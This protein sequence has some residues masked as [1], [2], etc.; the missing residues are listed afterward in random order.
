MTVPHLSAVDFTGFG[1]GH[2]TEL[3][4]RLGAVVLD[5]EVDGRRVR[6]TR[7]SV[8]APNAQAVRLVG[9]F[10]GWQG[11]RTWLERIEGTGI[12]ATFCEG[13]GS[14]ALYKFEVQTADGSWLTK[15][16][17]MARFCESA[18]HTA[19]IVYES[20]YRWNDDDWLWYRGETQ[21]HAAPMSVYEVHLGSWRPGLGYSQ[22]ADELVAHVTAM[23]FTHVEFLPVAEHPYRGSWGY[24]VTGFF[25]PQSRLGT[26][27][28][29]R[30]LV[31][32]LHRAG[33]GVIMDWVPGHFATDEWA[34][35][36]FDGTALYEHPDPRRGWHPDWGS[37]I[38]DFGR[39]EVRSFLLSNALWWVDQFHIDALRVDAVAS[40][41][42]LDYS[43]PDGGWE[44]NVHGGREN[45][46]A[47]SLLQEVNSHLYAR[48]PGVTMIAEESTT[49]PGVTRRVDQGGLGFG[50]K[51]NMGWM[52]DSLGYLGR[53]PEHR[54][55]HHHELTF[56]MTYS[57]SEN[58]VLPIS[59]DEVVHGKGSMYERVPEDP[60]RKFA[61]LKAYYAFMWSHPGKQLIFMGTEFAQRRE[62][63]EERGIDWQESDQWGHRA[64]LR[65]V[66]E[67]N[68]I[69][70]EHPALWRADTD[71]SGFR[72]ID[73]DNAA[74]NLYS[75]LRFDGAGDIIACVINFSPV[76]RQDV[77]IGLPAA[78]V[79]TELL[80]TDTDDF[81][82][83]GSYGNLGRVSTVEVPSHGFEQSAEV[84]VGPL[85]AVFLHFDAEEDPEPGSTDIA[86]VTAAQRAQARVA[87]PRATTTSTTTPRPAPV[88]NLNVSSR[89]TSRQQN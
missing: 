54:S 37:Y 63:S 80:N 5:A 82:G 16:D 68:R 67:L 51:W 7:F 76:P 61:T 41:L 39:P 26:P 53:R 45:L 9:D 65:T 15:A 64:V 38:F 21:F 70:R 57:Y 20:G 30:Y 3:W 27:D 17:P 44:P 40:M 66:A 56:S 55:Y 86:T 2:D 29:F 43:R 89:S 77:R 79:W 11:D 74:D 33:I 84:T 28:D 73:A 10:N 12:W 87:S 59:H 48:K 71:P 32:S 83:T 35:A 88:E 22:L 18:P 62:F 42:Y 4:R 24:H 14:G 13:V 6:G 47:I 49:Y 58:F 25:A 50:F 46:E 8:W 85:S 1:Q 81:D 69:Y 19:S 34:L 31:D 52:N 23:G 75:Y 72:W 36:K 78:G 60:W